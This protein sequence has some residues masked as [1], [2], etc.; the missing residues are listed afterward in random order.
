MW[1]KPP[2]ARRFIRRDLDVSGVGWY[3]SGKERGRMNRV[4]ERFGNAAPR[5]LRRTKANVPVG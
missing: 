2:N 4:V 1:Y 5:V 3:G